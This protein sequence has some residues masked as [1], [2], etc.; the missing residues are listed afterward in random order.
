L[1]DYDR[2]LKPREDE[3]NYNIFYEIIN[4]KE[5]K[6]KFKTKKS[7]DYKI[8]NEIEQLFGVDDEENYH[9]L[10]VKLKLI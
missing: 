1:A 6:E 8:L 9:K 10:I 3:R 4:N 5:L 7:K 2:V